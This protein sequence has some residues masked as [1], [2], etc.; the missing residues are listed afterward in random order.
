LRRDEI[1]FLF[2]SVQDRVKRAGAELV[3]VP[4]QFLDHGEAIHRFLD[5]M[6][7][8]MEPNQAGVKIAV[9]CV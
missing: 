4:S 3:T 1:A 2:K 8:H 5:R 6:M 7:E 9:G